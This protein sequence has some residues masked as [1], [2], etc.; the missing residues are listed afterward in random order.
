MLQFKQFLRESYNLKIK[1]VNE[2]KRP[3]LVLISRE[4]TRMFLNEE[5]MVGLMEELGFR[6]IITVPQNMSDLGKYVEV[7]NSCS[8]MVGSHRAGLTN[9]V[10]LAS[11]M[12]LVQ[13]VPLGLEWASTAF[14]GKPAGGLGVKYLE[15]RINP[16]ESPLVELYGRDYPVIMDPESVFKKGYNAARA[17]YVDGQNMKINLVIG[18]HMLKHL[19]LLDTELD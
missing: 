1:D 12:V 14:F 15:Y 13:V 10:F 17:V 16:K 9:E 2:I 3:V 18:R 5:E 7:V 8:I 19:F 11:G 4:K 6:V